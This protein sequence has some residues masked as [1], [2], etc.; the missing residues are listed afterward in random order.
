MSNQPYGTIAP[1]AAE[2][3]SDS[4]AAAEASSPARPAP[5]EELGTLG[6]YRLI[7]LLGEGGMGAVY[8]AEDRRRTGR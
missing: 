1:P 7:R 5:T 8:Q 3:G 4:L 6:H 2:T